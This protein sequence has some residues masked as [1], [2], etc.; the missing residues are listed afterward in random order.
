MFTKAIFAGLA[1]VIVS[2]AATP[3]LARGLC[4]DVYIEALNNTGKTIKIID[5]DYM[6]SGYGMK[7][8]PVKNTDRKNG[9]YFTLERN[10]E[11]ANERNTQVI[12][13]YRERTKNKHF[14]KWSGVKKAKSAYQECKKNK[15]YRI[16][17]D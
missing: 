12:V 8:E 6:I 13:K 17:I 2:T 7:S 4:R 11:E 5:V 9:Q 15:S 10:L 16:T 3:T 1:A 14:N